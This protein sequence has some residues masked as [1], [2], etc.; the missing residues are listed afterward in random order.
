M[1]SEKISIY[2]LLFFFFS[3][4]LIYKYAQQVRKLAS[5]GAGRQPTQLL[6]GHSCHFELVGFPDSHLRTTPEF[7]AASCCLLWSRL[8]SGLTTVLRWSQWTEQW[9][10][11]EKKR[12]HPPLSFKLKLKV[13]GI[14]IMDANIAIFTTTAVTLPI[15][16]KSNTVY[17]TKVTL[18]SAKLFFKSQVEEPCLKFANPGGGRGHIHGL[19]PTTEHDMI[20]NGRECS[21]VHRSL[22]PECLQ[23]F[24]C[25]AVK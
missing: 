17:R 6:S 25:C 10:G 21:R 22:C 18:Y 14:K 23:M 16:V 12:I 20:K 1:C 19:L 2:F 15:R 8:T 11:R 13:L 24:Q 4:P 9:I 3:S 5:T 7:G